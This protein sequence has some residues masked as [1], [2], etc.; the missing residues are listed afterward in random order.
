M[1]LQSQPN[2]MQSVTLGALNHGMSAVRDQQL[3]TTKHIEHISENLRAEA[4]E[5]KQ[6]TAD[7]TAQLASMK[8]KLTQKTKQPAKHLQADTECYVFHR[9]GRGR[10]G[11]RPSW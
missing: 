4:V 8:I 10:C 6:E 1:D 3:E 2:Q 11:A 9:H 7:I 5:R